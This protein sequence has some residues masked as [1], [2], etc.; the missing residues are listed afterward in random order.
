MYL[1]SAMQGYAFTGSQSVIQLLEE[2]GLHSLGER[3]KEVVV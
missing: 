2:Q 3:K 1:Q